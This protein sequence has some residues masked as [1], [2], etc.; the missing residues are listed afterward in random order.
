MIP[1]W[2]LRI[3]R[4]L[5]LQ[6]ADL[7][8]IAVTARKGDIAM[9]SRKAARGEI[10]DDAVGPLALVFAATRKAQVLIGPGHSPLDAFMAALPPQYVR[11]W[12]REQGAKA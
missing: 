10:P 3:G 11:N 1:A 6:E 7:T 2:M 9:F 4:P 12:M 8:K 5:S